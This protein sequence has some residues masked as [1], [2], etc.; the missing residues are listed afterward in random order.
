MRSRNY[1]PV[2]FPDKLT[3]VQFLCPPYFLHIQMNIRQED[4]H[5]II[6]LWVSFIWRCGAGFHVVFSI[7]VCQWNNWWFRIKAYYFP[8]ICL[9]SVNGREFVRSK[10]LPT[11]PIHQILGQDVIAE[12]GT[13]TSVRSTNTSPTALARIHHSKSSG[14]FRSKPPKSGFYLP[15]KFYRQFS[16]TQK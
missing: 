4:S 3:H 10:T 1:F 8:F 5:A 12:Y 13:P 2:V 7:T 11:I 14:S 9:L 16:G 6:F 15:G